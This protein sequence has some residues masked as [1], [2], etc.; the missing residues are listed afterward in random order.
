MSWTTDSNFKT[1]WLIF[2]WSYKKEFLIK[3][4]RNTP[5]FEVDLQSRIKNIFRFR[6]QADTIIALCWLKTFSAL[7]QSVTGL[8]LKKDTPK[9]ENSGYFRI[10]LR[11]ILKVH[12]KR[13]LRVCSSFMFLMFANNKNFIRCDEQ[14]REKIH[15]LTTDLENFHSLKGNRNC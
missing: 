2:E 14:N 6:F 9:T 13:I 5:S 3:C 1:I 4:F 12:F 7:F 10:N 15:K 8:Q 11:K